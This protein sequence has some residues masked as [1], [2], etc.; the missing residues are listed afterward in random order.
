M[1]LF[2]AIATK[3]QYWL[4]NQQELSL[5]GVSPN[6][7]CLLAGSYFSSQ[8]FN[9]THLIVCSDQDEAEEVFESLKHLKNVHFYPG[10]NHSL[11]SS[12]MTSESALLARWSVLQRLQNNSPE[13]IVTTHEASVLLGP[14]RSFFQKNSFSIKKDDIISPF[15]LAKK[16]TDMG[17]FPAS[18]IEEPGTFSRRGEIFDIYPISHPPVRLQYFDDLI[19]E[20]FSIDLETQKTIREKTYTELALVPGAGYL[21]K[22]PYATMLRS[23]IPQAQPAFKNKY[24]ARKQLLARV[25]ENQLFENY[26]LYIPLFFEKPES[27]LDYLPADAKI[28]FIN[29]ENGQKNLE[30]FL[31]SQAEDFE[32]ISEDVESSS[33]IPGIENFYLPQFPKTKFKTLFVDQLDIAVNLETPFDKELH[34]NF[35][36]LKSYLQTKLQMSGSVPDNKFE[37]IKG[38]LKILRK[39][40]N[41]HGHLVVNY[42]SENARQELQYLLEENKLTE[43]GT[44]LQF[45]YGKLDEGFYYKNENIFVL[46]EGDFFSVKKKKT[47]QVKATNKDLFAEQIATLKI[48]D[49]VIHRD[50]G[51][52]V[53]KGLET[54]QAGDQQ[55]DYLVIHYEDNDKV[56][57]PVYKLNLVQKHADSSSGLK[58]ASLKSKKFAELKT[59]ARG[60][61]K[62]LAFDLLK[63][64]AERKLRGGYPFSAPDH[65][66]KEFE[67]SFA[68]EETPDQS[69]A[70][71]DVLDDMQQQYP[72]DRLVC[73]DVG[74]GKTEVAMR[75]AMKA[76]LDKKQVVLLVPTTV[77]ALQHYHSFKKR[78]EN[79]PVN[80]DM[81]SRFKTAKQK[82]ET[83]GLVAEGK[84]DILVGTHAVLSDKLEFHDLGLL[85]IDEE[86]RF[87]VA[88]KEKLKV[89]KTGVDVL[90]MTATPIPRTLQLSFLGIRDLSLIQT[91]P[92]RRQAI[93]TYIIKED[94]LTLKSA[95]EKELSRGGQIY[96]VHNRVHDIEEHEIYLKKLVP[97]ARISVTHGQMN[98]RELE[99][100]IN[101]FYDHKADI[102][103]ATTIIESG[104][105]IPNAN[106]MIIDRAD[107]YGLAQ[108]HQL[109]GRIGRSDRKAYAYFIVPENRIISET[110]QRRLHAL[111]TYAEMG[112]GFALASSDM[113]IRGAG[114][115]LGGEQSGHIEAIG[116]EFYMDLLQE[117]I[118]EIR[119]EQK[120]S[121]K[122]IEIQAPFSAYIP[123]GY[124]P[125]HALRL[126]Y[127][128]R[129]SN[130]SDLGR[131][132]DII[133]E[134][135]DAFGITP[136]ELEALY[137]ILRSRIIFQPLGLRLVKV[138]GT[139][140]ALFFDQEILN[141]NHQLRDKML[142][143]FM[144][145]P[146]LYKINPD[147]SV[148]ALFKETV[149][150]NTL[151]EFAK[152]IAANMGV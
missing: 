27:L 10:H 56:Y 30:L 18:T 74:F 137:S 108:L 104:I 20:I 107:T 19:E 132:E 148:N 135:T 49:Y 115:I 89:L 66:F 101:D 76:V 29:N 113:E 53:Y 48:N 146:K 152:H 42:K 111:Q 131:L 46:S 133:S 121:V 47:K 91:A 59:K 82:T 129:L 63:L 57:V 149:S 120:V 16:L 55:N 3:I 22:D 141:H 109:R 24:E 70:I 100:R 9:S 17:Y 2:S 81:I 90:T 134:L 136:K 4:Q 114:D 44:R 144:N 97:S 38:S 138:G 25:S 118:Q 85:I 80:V 122:N 68:F 145:K 117:A 14:D 72:M 127:Y 150:H 86:H 21:T 31:A 71:Q 5:K 92:P 139:Q 12:I 93:K 78:F 43:I 69:K 23:R 64:Q 119:G 40:L 36:K 79:F 106:T 75:A 15:D 83:M 37:Y 6:Q 41:V 96:Y 84:V 54:I 50:Y 126:K 124:I 45:V 60:S 1:T 65:L 7:W 102:L 130:C 28:T 8:L 88:H 125:D 98:E 99:K 87:G 11:Y 110:A 73:G 105:D 32:D 112:S 95:I 151:L 51:I 94:D 52:G 147:S 61:V 143:F 35:E 62:K 103:L 140:I 77:L 26:P 128:K 58:V 34:L 13:I 33:V 116:L 142:N 67:L 39:E 123:N